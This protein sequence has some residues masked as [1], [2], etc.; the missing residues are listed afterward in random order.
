MTKKSGNDLR[1][2]ERCFPCKTYDLA[3]ELYELYNNMKIVKRI[4]IQRLRW[5]EH[6]T[7]NDEDD[8]VKRT[9]DW[10]E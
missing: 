2:F 10:I 9:F 1:S 6:I 8:L 4:Q 5:F 3:H 7:P